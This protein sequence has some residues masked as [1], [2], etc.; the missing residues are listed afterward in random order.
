MSASKSSKRRLQAVMNETEVMD[1]SGSLVPSG[2]LTELPQ[3]W[4]D[5]YRDLM[6][7]L[8][9]AKL[10]REQIAQMDREATVYEAAL[11]SFANYL[12]KL[13]LGNVGID[14]DGKIVRNSPQQ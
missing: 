6:A 3:P 1:V 11:Q 14:R 2:E 5:Y 9:K 13:G 12:P 8:D 7:N 4:L 10:M